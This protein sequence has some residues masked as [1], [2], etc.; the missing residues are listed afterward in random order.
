MHS[1]GVSDAALSPKTRGILAWILYYLLIEASR[2]E[3]MSAWTKLYKE[4]P[5]ATLSSIKIL[6]CFFIYF[7]PISSLIVA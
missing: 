7:G 5:V 4:D 6:S 3:S 1:L 2:L